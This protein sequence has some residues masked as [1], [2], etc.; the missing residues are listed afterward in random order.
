MP[1]LW[2]QDV[3]GWVNA[4]HAATKL[5]VERGFRKSIPKERT[6]EREFEAE[7]ARLEEF[8]RVREQTKRP[9]G[10]GGQLRSSHRR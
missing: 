5:V 1:M 4:S 6:F 9:C 7:L 8:L 10:D 3:I 2:R